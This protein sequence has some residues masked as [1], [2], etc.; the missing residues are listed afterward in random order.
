M[1]SPNQVPIHL[2]VRFEEDRIRQ[3]LW[4][5]VNNAC[6]AMNGSGTLRV[7]TEEVPVGELSGGNVDN[8]FVGNWATVGGSESATSSQEVGRDAPAALRVVVED[9]GPG[10][11]DEGLA[12]IF[13]PFYTTRSGGTGLGLAIVA[14]IV[15]A[16]QGVI[17]VHTQRG[18]G[19]CFAVWLPIHDG[20]VVDGTA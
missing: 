14:R 10:I 9:T 15:Q 18:E 5:L 1:W 17:T 7:R 12:R 11:S 20:D 2:L 8:A 13:D 19:T 4:N 16:H 6:Q 3:V